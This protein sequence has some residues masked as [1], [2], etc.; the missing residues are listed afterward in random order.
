MSVP[1][2]P[3]ITM[4]PH[5]QLVGYREVFGGESWCKHTVTQDCEA[6]P[7]RYFV[8]QVWTHSNTVQS[9]CKA[10]PSP[11]EQKTLEGDVLGEPS[12][13]TAVSVC[14]SVWRRCV[15]LKS[16]RRPITRLE[17]SQLNTVRMPSDTVYKERGNI[18]HEQ[19]PLDSNVSSYRIYSGEYLD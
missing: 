12:T 8:S 14:L 10:V 6:A 9:K 1:S 16:K 15:L 5:L 17:K 7:S 11:S 13:Q 2:Q 19:L 18:K 3:R 4:T